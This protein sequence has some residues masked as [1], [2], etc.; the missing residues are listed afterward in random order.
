M[1]VC[2]MGRGWESWDYSA[3]GR[4]RGVL[5]M[6]RYLMG[7]KRSWSQTLPSGAQQQ[8]KK[9]QDLTEI[10]DIPLKKKLF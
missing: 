4:L 3:W 6:C 10:E 5:S 2:P 7:D 1:I 9:E 8:D